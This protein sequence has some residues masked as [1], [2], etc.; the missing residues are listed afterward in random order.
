MSDKK[1]K[2]CPFCH[3]TERG[4]QHVDGFWYV[5]CY[6][7]IAGPAAE[8]KDGAREAWNTRHD[9]E[10]DMLVKALEINMR[11]DI[12]DLVEMN[13]KRWAINNMEIREVELFQDGKQVILSE[14]VIDALEINGLNNMDNLFIGITLQEQE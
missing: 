5:T 3:D 1:L 2:Y 4:F 9:P 13:E 14:E 6:C 12:E 10:K 11:V 7:G 8:T